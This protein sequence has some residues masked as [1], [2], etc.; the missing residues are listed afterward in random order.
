[1]FIC[2]LWYIYN[3]SWYANF[4]RTRVIEWSEFGIK[5]PIQKHSS[6]AGQVYLSAMQ[7]NS[8]RLSTIKLGD[9]TPAYVNRS[10]FLK[11]LNVLP[12][13]VG[14]SNAARLASILLLKF[15]L[16]YRVER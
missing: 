4:D 5:R 13:F 12:T 8:F 10:S 14:P 11:V 9:N 7:L 2:R 6:D 1:M 3:I 15:I 16:S